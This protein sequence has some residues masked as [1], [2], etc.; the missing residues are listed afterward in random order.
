LDAASTNTS[1][2]GTTASAVSY[3][4]FGNQDDDFNL[5]FSKLL[6]GLTPGA[7]T[8]TLQWLIQPSNGTA[9]AV[10]SQA[11]SSPSYYHRTISAIEF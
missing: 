1:L 11:N 4:F 7:H 5:A 9:Y 6:T 10:Y 3:D 8:L 2:G